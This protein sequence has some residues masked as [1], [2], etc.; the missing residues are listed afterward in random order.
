MPTEVFV[1]NTTHRYTN[2]ITCNNHTIYSDQPESLNGDDKGPSPFDL[3]LSALGSCTSIT[4]KMYAERKNIQL[5]VINIRL[6]YIPP[7]E[8]EGTSSRIIRRI[9]I[10]GDFTEDQHTRML[11]IADRCPVHQTLREKVDIMSCFE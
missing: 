11:E 1:E 10:E 4:L 3:L 6:N 9:H 2:K 8:I 7:N 5:D